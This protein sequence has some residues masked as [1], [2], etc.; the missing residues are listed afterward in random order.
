MPSR[1]SL[2][3]LLFF[4]ARFLSQAGQGAFLAG[5]F[6]LAGRG[7]QTAAGT[8]AVFVAMMAAALVGGLPAGML[9]DHM[10][11]GRAFRLGALGRTLAIGAAFWAAA[12]PPPV[13]AVA[14]V[15]AAAF[16]YSAASQL[17]CSA[18]MALVAPLAPRRTAGTHTLLSALQ[19][20][21]QGCGIAVLTPAM[22]WFGGLAAVLG[23]ALALYVAVV[24]AAFVLARRMAGTAPAGKRAQKHSIADTVRYFGRE[25]GAAGAAVLLAFG[26]MTVKAMAIVL[27]GYVGSDLHLSHE[28]MV[29]LAAAGGAGVVGGLTWAGHQLHLHPHVPVMRIILL[30]AVLAML[31]L[32][33]AGPLLAGSANAT[34]LPLP[35]QLDSSRH[36]SFAV[37]L[38][39]ALVLG[40]CFA[41]GPIGARSMLSRTAPQGQQAKVFAMQ[42][43]FSDCLVI[44]PLTLAGAGVE[45]AGAAV[46]FLFIAALG[47]G[48]LTF[49]R[50][51][52][53]HSPAVPAA[54]AA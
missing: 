9:A 20:C 6:L 21:G 7:S 13:P 5:L 48:A 28:Q 34:G 18:E 41:I 15:A 45:L 54:A 25:R 39:A 43:T 30:S 24:A 19:Y 4:S 23:A 42:S 51:V 49:F 29:L 26:E 17:Y 40:V 31:A 53:S 38:P 3:R 32:A 37:A 8:S 46:A 14:V 52:P 35:A 22:L 44:V 36:A 47:V 27:P 50:S 2:A 11:P 10:G 16:S 1:P 12:T 33:A